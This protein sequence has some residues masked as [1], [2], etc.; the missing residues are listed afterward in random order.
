MIDDTGNLKE[1]EQL[2]QSELEKSLWPNGG[3]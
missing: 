2:G 1:Q 3:L